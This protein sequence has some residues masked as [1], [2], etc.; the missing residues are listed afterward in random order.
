MPLADNVLVSSTGALY[1]APLGTTAPTGATPAWNVAFKELGFLSEDGITENPSLD[2]E[3]IKAW[4]SGTVIRKVITG[5]G[6]E[7]SFDVI[8][9]NLTIL[10]LFYPGSVITAVTG[11]PAET[12]VEVKL[13]VATFKAFGI[14]LVDGTKLERIIVPRAS[15]SA[16]GERNY[17]NPS[18]R[19]FPLTLSASPDSAG[20]TAIRYLNPQLVAV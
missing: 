4:Q 7:F 15:I 2:S 19:N 14:D 1:I 20:V 16:R 17:T 3:E 8:E 6:L 18:A 9:T 5:S 13:P 10:E 12:K 11:P